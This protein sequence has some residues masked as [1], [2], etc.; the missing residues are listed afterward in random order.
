MDEELKIKALRRGL[1]I[2][3]TTI[4]GVIEEALTRFA[5]E[6]APT[7]VPVSPIQRPAA[8]LIEIPASLSKEDRE[9]VETLIEMLQVDKNGATPYVA[10]MKNWRRMHPAKDKRS[11]QQKAG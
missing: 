6:K 8:N 5:G 3:V 11:S 2:G 1:D 7:S 4:G 9:A 10:L